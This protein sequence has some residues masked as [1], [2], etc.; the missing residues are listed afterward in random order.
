M[1]DRVLAVLA[2]LTLVCFLAVLVW[3]V[4]RWDL[5]LVVLITV[6][7]AGF[8]TAQIMRRH[9]QG[10]TSDPDRSGPDH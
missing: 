4:P 1:I 5:G 9:A 10:E 8:D 2:Y 6:V 7:L 3:H